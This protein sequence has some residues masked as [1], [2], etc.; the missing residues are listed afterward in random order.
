[1]A[2]SKTASSL[3]GTDIT[4]LE[5][6]DTWLGEKMASSGRAEDCHPVANANSAESRMKSLRLHPLCKEV[7]TGQ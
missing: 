4:G 3:G 1:M 2:S 7:I 6:R 5:F